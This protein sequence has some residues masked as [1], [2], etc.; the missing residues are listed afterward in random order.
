M[1]GKREI[2]KRFEEDFGF[3][4]TQTKACV[5]AVFT[6]MAEIIDE[7]PPGESV[8]FNK[9]GCMKKVLKPE[10]AKRN[11]RTGETVIVP[12]REVVRIKLSKKLKYGG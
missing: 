6:Y 1:N 9:F 10:S 2:Y 3:S 4:A 7:L 11:P 8:T 5:D 12:E